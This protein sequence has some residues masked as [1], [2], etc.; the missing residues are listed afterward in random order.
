LLFFSGE[1]PR[2]RRYGR[3]AALRLIVQP[4]DVA[5]MEWNWQ[6]KAEVLGE[7]P[8]PMPLCPLQIL[9][10]L[11]RNRT[12]ASAVGGRRLTA[13]AMARPRYDMFRSRRGSSS[14]IHSKNKIKVPQ[15]ETKLFHV[16]K[17]K[18]YKRLLT[19]M[20]VKMQWMFLLP[21]LS[22]WMFL[23]RWSRV[24][25]SDADSWPLKM[26]SIRCPETSVD[27]YYT[28]P[29]NIVS[30]EAQICSTGKSEENFRWE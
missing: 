22:S 26:R 18:I 16:T 13:W 21:C 1:G 9:H 28:T 2:S 27:N 6:G 8:V 25:V 14:G 20:Y 24:G 23:C 19:D 7:K 4:Y 15:S 10:G 11:T 12:R 3:T 5:P 30:Q 29:R 17:Y